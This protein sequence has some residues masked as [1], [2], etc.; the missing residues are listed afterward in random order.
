MEAYGYKKVAATVGLMVMVIG[1]SMVRGEGLCRMTKEG[2]EACRPSVSGQNPPPPTKA[3]CS[4]L[5]SADLPCL[6]R[7]KSSGFLSFYGIDPDA[8]MILPL[9]CN[10]VQS[11]FHC[12]LN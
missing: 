2:L 8:A 12:Q 6:C 4:A 9:H 11:S 3:C 10:I 7:F 5:S 1:A